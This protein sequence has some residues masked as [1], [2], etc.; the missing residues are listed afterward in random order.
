MA[1]EHHKGAR[2]TSGAQ[3]TGWP[4][5]ELLLR[6]TSLGIDSEYPRNTIGRPQLTLG[7]GYRVLEEE[8]VL[9]RERRGHYH[10]TQ[11][12]RRAEPRCMRTRDCATVQWAT[13]DME[14]NKL[15]MW[16]EETGAEPR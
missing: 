14:S 12:T 7:S 1:R 6:T 13:R 15:A 10:Y 9:N 2:A 16:E 4:Y 5:A 11:A 3:Y 8:Y